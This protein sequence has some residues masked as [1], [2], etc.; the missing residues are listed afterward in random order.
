MTT[1]NRYWCQVLDEMRDHIKGLNFS[2]FPSLIEEL[3]TMGNRMEAGLYDKNDY[4][5]L[6]EEISELDDQIEEL[7]SE[8]AELE[9]IKGK[10]E[11]KPLPKGRKKR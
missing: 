7:R 8:I 3:Q 1:P 11:A 9:K 10:L 6:R 2:M 4:N 5:A